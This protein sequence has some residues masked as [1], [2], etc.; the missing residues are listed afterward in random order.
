MR[1]LIKMNLLGLFLMG[2]STVFSQQER[3][4]PDRFW[5]GE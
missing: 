3:R 5:L 1:E 2:V 4:I